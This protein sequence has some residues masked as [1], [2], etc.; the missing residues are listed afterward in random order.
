MACQILVSNKSGIPKA[1]IVTIVDG[2]HRFSKFETMAEWVSS[3]E[4]Q[5]EWSRLFSLIIVTDKDKEEIMY[6]CDT[7]DGL[8]NKYHFVE[9]DATSNFYKQLMTNGEVITTFDNVEKYIRER[10]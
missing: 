5:S 4:N 9:P 8:I 7:L 10:V 1:E 3:G 2:N 6:L